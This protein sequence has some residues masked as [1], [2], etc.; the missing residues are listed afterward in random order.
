MG[1]NDYKK[2][3][4]GLISTA[5]SADWR[6]HKGGGGHW[7]FLPADPCQ[8]IVVA[9]ATASDPRAINNV[10]AQLRRAGLDV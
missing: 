7:K 10:R 6:V 1:N 5:E 4:N 3:L 9:A 2:Q 8:G